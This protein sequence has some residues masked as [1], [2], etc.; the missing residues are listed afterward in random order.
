MTPIGAGITA[1]GLGKMGIEA[2]IDEREKIPLTTNVM[3]HRTVRNVGLSFSI[4]NESWSK[5]CWFSISL[6]F[7]EIEE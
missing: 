7:C 6:S 5:K 1:L 4:I 3:I 2:A